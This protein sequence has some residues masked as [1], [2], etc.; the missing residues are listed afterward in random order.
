MHTPQSHINEVH[1][2][3]PLGD[4]GPDIAANKVVICATGHNSVHDLLGLWRKAGGEPA[5]DVR[6]HYS[7]GE[8]ALAATGWDRIQRQA[9]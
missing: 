9:M 1:H 6:Q 3:W 8:R 2:V 4:N 5:W 7:K